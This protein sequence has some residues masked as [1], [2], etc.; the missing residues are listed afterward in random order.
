MP[1]KIQSMEEKTDRLDSI[2]IKNLYSAKDNVNRMRRQAIDWKKIVVKGPLSKIY[3]E[4]L[5][6]NK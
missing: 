2:K 1:P 6:L 5:K 4:V 3:K